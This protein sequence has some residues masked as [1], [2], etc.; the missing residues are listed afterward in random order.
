MYSIKKYFL[1]LILVISSILLN[2]QRQVNILQV[3]GKNE[4]C[5]IDE[6][7]KSVLPSGRYLTPAGKLIRITHDP[8]G[9][10]ISPDGK[11]AVTLHN[12]VFTIIDL[13]SLSHTR[14]PS[15]D[16]RLT[17]PLSSGS[18]LGVAFASDSKTIFLSGGDNGAVIIYD[19]STL[20]RLD[21]ISL[22][23]KIDN[24][25]FDDSF[26]SDLLLNDNKNE[27]LV[28]DRGNFRMVRIDLTLKKITASIK[29]GRQ[30]FGLS[31]SPDKKTAFV[32]NVGMYEYPLVTGMDSSNYN[33]M[34]VNWHPYADNTKESINGTIIDGKKIPGVGSPLAPEAMSVFTI[35]L[36]SNKVINKFKTGHQVGQ[37]I[38]DAEVVGGASPNSIAVGSKYAYVTNATNDN[39][40]VID[41]RSRKIISHIPIRADKRIDKYRG[42]LPFGI[43]LSKDEKTLYVALLGFNAVAVIDV[44]T[45]KTKGLIPTG[46]GPAR[47]LLSKDE[48]EMYVISC[49]GLGAGP[50]GGKDFIKPAQG[51]YIGDVQLASFQKINIPD[52]RQLAA[53]TRQSIN[54]T[55][56]SVAIADDA[57]HPL[58]PLPNMRKSP[59]KHI[60]YI[61]KENR[62]Y[63]EVLGQ[64]KTGKGDKTLARYG[65][66]VNVSD[67]NDTLKVANADVMPNHTKLASEFSYADNFYCDS[68]A[69]IHGHHWMVGVIPNEWVET[70]SS[71][72]K[73]AKIFS[74][75][76]GRRFP[77]ST[78][79]MDPEDYA[80]IGGLWEALERNKISFYN[81][82]E[83]N[84]TAHVREEWYD[85]LTGAAH[86]VMVPMQKALWSRTSH[87]YAGYNTNI[88]DQFRMEQF[89]SEFTKMWIDGKEEMPKLITMQV[90]NDHG[91]GVRP[92]HGYPYVHSYMADNDLAVGR[93]LH[94]LSRT[95]YWKNMLVIVT[96]DDP[97]GG[98]DHVD[99]HRSVLMMAGPYIKR[100]YVS[101]THAN[102][103]SILKL[104]YNI[105]GVNY[106]NQYDVTAS[107]LSDFFTNKPDYTPYSLVM[108]DKRVFDPQEAMKRYN[109]TIDWRKIQ[110][111][112]EMD[113]EDEQRTDHY[114]KKN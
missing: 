72:S 50:N 113:D 8:F 22:N 43:A 89:E 83:A 26:T 39:I 108:P 17:S 67:I 23:G 107:L 55:F 110:Q 30:P 10:A 5:K 48:K 91:A 81:F 64:M 82:G 52:S 87:N 65:V 97:Q 6:K 29:V 61:T 71:V 100:N 94:F 51:T 109:K 93:I 37:M 95:K 78:G 106:V 66:N 9:M 21:S 80:E 68:D 58:P 90:P 45:H 49:R 42:L 111:G 40:S 1:F 92:E 13:S 103:G 77:G 15:Y 18:F 35:D 12:G 112:P 88:P 20:M 101:H 33:E 86:A 32:A 7:G 60:V 102:F 99:A 85:T 25:N 73:T 53:Y 34:M 38:E 28:L 27:L 105:L 84:E 70:N 96:E 19:I 36:A 59:V 54:N 14:I 41:T 2:A 62:T 16:G 44:I 79:S 76:P 24:V 47:V 57:R 69:S 3:P 114:K 4:F 98:V 46:W 31:L 75:A 11:K 74:K 56:Q 104:I 63:D